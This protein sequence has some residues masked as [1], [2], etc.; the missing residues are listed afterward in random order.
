LPATEGVGS[1][2]AAIDRLN[3][4]AADARFSLNSGRSFVAITMHSIQTHSKGEGNTMDHHQQH[5]MHQKKEREQ[6][7]K[8]EK[9]HDREEEQQVRKIHP[10][11][12]VAIGVAFIVLIVLVWTFYIFVFA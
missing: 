12:F 3:W 8:H 7:K 2:Y 9:E 1:P 6:E 10:A 4:S 5:E 11:W